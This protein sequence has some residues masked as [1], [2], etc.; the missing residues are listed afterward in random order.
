MICRCCSAASRNSASRVALQPPLENR[1]HLFRALARG[2][3]DV[4]ESEALLVSPISLGNFGQ[5]ALVRRARLRLLGLGP[6]GRLRAR[7]RRSLCVRRC[8]DGRQRPQASRLPAS[9]PTRGLPPR[10]AQI[11][12]RWGAGPPSHRPSVSMPQ[13]ASMAF[14]AFGFAGRIPGRKRWRSRSRSLP[15]QLEQKLFEQI[16]GHT[17]PVLGRGA[18]IVDRLHF[19]EQRAPRGQHRFTRERAGPAAPPQF[20]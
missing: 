8:G 10:S 7:V 5:H 16:H 20:A 11:H 3:H 2:A 6:R 15:A 4:R 19:G 12:S 14:R 9:C 13:Q 1:Q 17:P 18:N